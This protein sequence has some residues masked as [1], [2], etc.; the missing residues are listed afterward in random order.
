MH[1]SNMYFKG[2]PETIITFIKECSTLMEWGFLYSG[3]LKEELLDAL[4]S[5]LMLCSAKI[6][7]L[8]KQ[9]SSQLCAFIF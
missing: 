5:T 2:K 3:P 7:L 1:A 9:L 4:C 6:F 8:S